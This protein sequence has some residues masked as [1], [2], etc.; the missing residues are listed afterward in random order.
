MLMNM[1]T[2]S[3]EGFIKGIILENER[4]W[5]CESDNIEEGWVGAGRTFR[6]LNVQKMQYNVIIIESLFSAVVGC[7]PQ[8]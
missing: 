1:A 8:A 3:S 5:A 4:K 7:S 2:V 6:A